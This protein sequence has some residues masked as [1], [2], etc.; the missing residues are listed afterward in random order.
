MVDK[1]SRKTI[2]NLKT[3]SQKDGEDKENTIYLPD[4]STISLEDII[5]KKNSIKQIIDLMKNRNFI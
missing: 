5:T 1:R 4:N 3:D 2:R